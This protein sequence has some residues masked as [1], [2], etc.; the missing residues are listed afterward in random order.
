M[1]IDFTTLFERL[2]KSFQLGNSLLDPAAGEVPTDLEDFLDSLST[3][4]ETDQQDLGAGVVAGLASY[5]S[6][7]QQAVSTL[8]QTPARLL[9]QRTIELHNEQAGQSLA[10]SLAELIT[11]MQIEDQ[12]VEANAV[13][14]LVYYGGELSSSSLGAPAGNAGDGVLLVSTR[15]G[16]GRVNEFIFSET[17]DLDITAAT[18]G[19]SATWTLVGQPATSPLAWNH[20][21]GSGATRTI[22]S[23]QANAQ[24][25][26][27]NGTF[28]DEDANATDLPDQWIASV[29]TLG[30]TLRLTDIETQT[31][32][33]SGTPMGG[34]YLLKWT[35][36]NSQVHWTVP[37][38]YNA[39]ASAVQTALRSL[40]ELGRVS[41]AATGVSP[42]FTHTVTLTG[43]TNPA[44]LSSLSGLTGGSPAINHATTLAASPYVMRGSRSLELD[45]DGAQ[46][47]AIQCPV[48]VAER[49]VYGLCLWACC[50]V[51][52]AQ[53]VLTIELVD[54]IGGAVLS[55]DEGES[56]ATTIDCT[57]LTTSY[58]PTA[59]VF[60]TPTA[61]PTTAYLRI[62]ISTAI[63]GGTSVFLDEVAM[64]AMTELY[65]GGLF[66]AAF[67]GKTDHQV[68]DD[69]QIQVTNDFA[70]ELHTWCDRVF[71]LR[72]ARLLLPSDTT[73]NET[74]PDSLIA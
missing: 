64:R 4:D 6:A 43:V 70:G 57:A 22:P 25:L 69:A 5:Q 54:G 37:L 28:E 26:V 14:A 8:V 39:S 15:R 1:A 55:D 12:T 50:D 62:R 35:D 72:A 61:V 74:L 23:L 65:P 30:T 32:T 52:P 7:A 20:P 60:R 40:P 46:L 33:I 21:Q 41:V 67:Q 3:M 11:Q 51:T 44:Q 63:S 71:G 56:C 45:S 36:S 2:G 24:N 19:G 13:T 9:L 17:I 10:K 66:V 68:G 59:V 38:A 47:T 16:D 34:Y 31:V 29:A 53:G 27:P 42:N 49:T 73:G 18:R 58:Q 48:T